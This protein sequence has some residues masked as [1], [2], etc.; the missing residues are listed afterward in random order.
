MTTDLYTAAP[1]SGS[2]SELGPVVYRLTDRGSR[3]GLSAVLDEER[4]FPFSR[5]RAGTVLSALETVLNVEQAT[6]T[7]RAVVD[8]ARVPATW[9]EGAQNAL[10]AWCMQ[11]AESRG[12]YEVLFVE[13]SGQN[14]RSR[15]TTLP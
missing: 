14:L 7:T 3:M 8:F 1:P 4:V 13:P 9:P 5:R 12:A 15:V 2:A 6:H 11:W 10:R